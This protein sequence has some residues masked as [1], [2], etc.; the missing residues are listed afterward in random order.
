MAVDDN[1]MNL[2][3]VKALLKRT[4]IQLET[5]ESGQE[6]M[7]NCRRKKYDLILMDHMMPELDGIETLHLLRK[8][9][10]PNR[11]TEVLV[12]TANVIA[13]MEEM[14][15]KEGFAGY[16]SKPLAVSELEEMLALHL[17]TEKVH[18]TEAK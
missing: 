12:L 17:P 8:E 7:E 9:E 4:Q 2:A 5:V 16:L 10:T 6:C 15:E 1:A 3:V 14:Y 18:W 13:G 11:E